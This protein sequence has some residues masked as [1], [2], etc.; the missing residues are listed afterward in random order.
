MI[1][2]QSTQ[3][4]MLENQVA[5]QASS[6][7]RQPSTLPGNP[8][9]NLREHCKAVILRNGFEYENPTITRDGDSIP[10]QNILP[11]VSAEVLTEKE[12]PK[13]SEEVSQQEEEPRY[14]PPP[15]K[16]PIPFPQRLAKVKKNKKIGKFVELLNKLHINIP[17]IEALT[18]M[19]SYAKFLKE[20]LSNKK[21]FEECETVAL[22]VDCS[23]LLLNQLPPKM[24]DLGS[25]TLPCSIGNVKLKKVLCDP[26][27]SVSLMPKSI[28]DKLGIEDLKPTRISLQLVDRSVRFSLGIIEDIT[29]QVGKFFIP[30]DFV[31]MEMEEDSQVP[32][33]LGRLFFTTAGANLDIKND[34]LSLAIGDEKIE[35][36]VIKSMKCP[37]NDDVCCRVEV[38][39]TLAAEVFNMQ[40]NMKEDEILSEAI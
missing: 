12:A 25:F 20:I 21:K 28:F 9:L 15:Y 37:S 4:K 26:G 38:M 31:V 24:K 40:I 1:K 10:P 30:G 7:S 6:S 11:R 3:I 35:F 23:A 18:Q 34:I 5:Q 27:A 17:F 29:V 19:P 32:I 16:P 22:T 2:Q 33:I 13:V 8:E 36:N 14:D 39:D